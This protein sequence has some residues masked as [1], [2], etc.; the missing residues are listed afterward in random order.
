MPLP[1]CHT[2]FLYALYTCAQYIYTYT[3]LKQHRST[4]VKDPVSSYAVG[5]IKDNQLVLVPLDF[6]LQLRPSM[7]YLQTSRFLLGQRFL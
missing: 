7:S 5:V 4:I 6:T 1:L 2:S 3:F